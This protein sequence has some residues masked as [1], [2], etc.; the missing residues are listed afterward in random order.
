MR[1]WSRRAVRSE[2]ETFAGAPRWSLMATFLSRSARSAL[3]AW[4]ERLPAQTR[5]RTHSEKRTSLTA[6][7]H[8]KESSILT[9][10]L[11]PTCSR[12]RG[13]SI[14]LVPH[15]VGCRRVWTWRQSSTSCSS[16]ASSCSFLSIF[17]LPPLPFSVF[18]CPAGPL[19]TQREKN[20]DVKS[21]AEFDKPSTSKLD[22][23]KL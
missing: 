15:S 23:H 6:A 9:W 2:E 5:K 17:S 4:G 12:V 18:C 10:L 19:E 7:R 22:T 3:P 11:D 8:P 14:G 1:D 16:L 21:L 13:R 20:T